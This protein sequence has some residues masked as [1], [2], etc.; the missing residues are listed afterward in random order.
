[1]IPRHFQIMISLLLLAILIVGIY[2]IQLRRG[3]QQLSQ[4]QATMAPAAPQAGGNVE[5]IHVLVAY[6]DDQAL[7]WRDSQVFMPYDRSLRAKAAMRAV[8]EQYLQKPSPHPVGKGAAIKDVY[9]IDSDTLLVD[10]TAAFA[11]EHPSG[12][13]LEE[14]TLASLIETVS[15]NVPGVNKVKFLVEGKERETLAGHADLMSF[16]QVSAVH[17]LAKE[18]E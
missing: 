17:E 2:I 1:V 14:M 7:R 12:I 16:Y 15:A 10:T 3:E 18:L 4:Q 11:D 5:S 9:L 13:L 8:L 6:D